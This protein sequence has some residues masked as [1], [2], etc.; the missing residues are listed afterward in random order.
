M[1]GC[2]KKWLLL[3]SG[4]ATTRKLRGHT[5]SSYNELLIDEN[6][7]FVNLINTETGY[8][9]ELANYSVEVNGN[10]YSICSYNHNSLHK[11]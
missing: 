7:I 6:G 3:N 11:S 2:L 8:K 5:Y 4:T 9:K 10:E 1:F